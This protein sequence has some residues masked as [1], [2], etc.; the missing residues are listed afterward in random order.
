MDNY[1]AMAITRLSHRRHGSADTSGDSVREARGH[2]RSHH[3]GH[4]QLAEVVLLS[5]DN[6]NDVQTTRV[7]RLGA[8][9]P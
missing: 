2:G 8:W 7:L 3:R 4:G 6:F 9:L 5:D 1:E